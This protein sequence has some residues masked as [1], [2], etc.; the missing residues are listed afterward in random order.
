M[1]LY[2]EVTNNLKETSHNYSRLMTHIN[3]DETFAIIGSQ[4]KDDYSID[5]YKE[6]LNAVKKLSLNSSTPEGT[7]RKVGY[8]IVDGLYT[9]DAG[10]LGNERSII[11]YNIDKDTAL[12]LGKELN[13][14]TIVWKDKDFFGTLYCDTGKEK[15]KYKRNLSFSGADAIGAGTKFKNDKTNDFGTVFVKEGV[16]KYSDNGSLKEEHFILE[17]EK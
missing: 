13:Q 16:L 2:E 15:D 8:N 10:K 9:Y 7:G 4:D 3:N 12:K 11:I 1:N 17:M 14:E 5:H 6:L